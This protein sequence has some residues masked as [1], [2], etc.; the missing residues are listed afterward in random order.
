M[1]LVTK[2]EF[3]NICKEF[4]GE[5][6]NGVYTATDIMEMYLNQDKE[7]FFIDYAEKWIDDNCRIGGDITSFGNSLYR[8]CVELLNYLLDNKIDIEY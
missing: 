7:M 2:E 1:K 6:E 3:L 4:E 5:N 8:T